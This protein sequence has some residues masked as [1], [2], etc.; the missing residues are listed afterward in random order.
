M[1]HAPYIRVVS[2]ASIEYSLRKRQ[3]GSATKYSGRTIPTVCRLSAV[4]TPYTENPQSHCLQK[5]SSNQ[6]YPAG[7]WWPRKRV[8]RMSEDAIRTHR[9]GQRLPHYC[10]WLR[11]CSCVVADTAQCDQKLITPFRSSSLLVAEMDRQRL[12]EHHGL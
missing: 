9:C 7:S 8:D 3:L 11:H 2:E 10:N 5:R 1:V 12:L 4:H 6:R